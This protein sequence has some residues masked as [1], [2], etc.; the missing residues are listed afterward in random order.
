LGA[1]GFFCFGGRFGVLSPIVDLRIV[2]VLPASNDVGYARDTIPRRGPVRSRAA[3]ALDP[4][5]AFLMRFSGTDRTL[6]TVA[7]AGR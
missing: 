6:G 3:A 7:S 5:G 4:T 1:F 2:R